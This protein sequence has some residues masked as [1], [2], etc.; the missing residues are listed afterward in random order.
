[1]KKMETDGKLYRIYKQ[2]G[3]HISTKKDENGRVSALQFRDEDNKLNGPLVMEEAGIDE[4]NRLN[5]Q[6]QIL[7]WALNE[8]VKPIV[9]YYL[10][11][12]TDRL[13]DWMCDEG[14]SKIKKGSG[15]LIDSAKL[16]ADAFGDA[17]SGKELK[18]IRLT[19]EASQLP[20]TIQSDLIVDETIKCSPDQI[21]QVIQTMRKSA[22]TMAACIQI[23][24][25]TIVES[26]GLESR[27]LEEAKKQFEQLSTQEIMNSITLMLEE[28]NSGLLD[29]KSYEI[30]SAFQHGDLLIEGRR[31]SIVKYLDL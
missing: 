27:E 18:A 22:V 26:K 11:V 5:E 19:R 10:M 24:T 6:H 8:I 23:L 28:K 30:L 1:M 25:K 29:A 12:G 7:N 21:E 13:I 2:P 31:E 3:N 15:K 14:I 17:L 20:N 4:S 16:F 9:E